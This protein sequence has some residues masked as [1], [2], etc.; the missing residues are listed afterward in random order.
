MKKTQP[1]I[2]IMNA[3][4]DIT[5]AEIRDSMDFAQVLKLVEAKN[6]LDVKRRRYITTGLII[7]GIIGLL[8]FLYV[9]VTP[10]KSKEV[11][12]K[13][14]PVNSPIKENHPVTDSIRST[15]IIE[16]KIPSKEKVKGPVGQAKQRPS[17]ELKTKADNSAAS[18]SGYTEAEPDAGYPHL[19]EY[20]NRELIYPAEALK[21]SIQGVI[22]VKFI[23]AENGK[24]EQVIIQNSL[25][26]VF[27][28]EALRLIGNMP[29]WKPALLDGRPVPS[30]ISVPLTFQVK[31]SH[32]R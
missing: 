24:P 8:L 17:T 30:K 15:A 10:S 5:D 1:K 23:I 25:G 13:K 28:K 14:M 2:K 19:Y 27:D 22:I 11:A 26:A 21:D 7:T 6:L 32:S 29:S 4:P 20:F 9:R 18:K 3:K 31:T 12:E 16:T